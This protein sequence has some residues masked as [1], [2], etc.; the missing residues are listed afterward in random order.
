MIKKIYTVSPVDGELLIQQYSDK[1]C[2]ISRDGI[3]YIDV[4]DIEEKEYI[5]TNIEI[6]ILPKP[7]I[8]PDYEEYG[9]SF[10]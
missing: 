10:L 3:N 9:P 5:E 7:E 2:Y 1:N 6:P 4:V 8:D